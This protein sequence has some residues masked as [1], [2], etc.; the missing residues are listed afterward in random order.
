MLPYLMVHPTSTGFPSSV[1][2]RISEFM[3][4]GFVPIN[5]S[6]FSIQ[7]H[8]PPQLFIDPHYSIAY[9][10]KLQLLFLENTNEIVMCNSLTVLTEFKINET[11]TVCFDIMDILLIGLLY[12]YP[13]MLFKS[14]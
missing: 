10:L 5:L 14:L 8:F 7:M 3:N 9:A 4:F 12:R 13:V 1:E 2:W 11:A 6:L